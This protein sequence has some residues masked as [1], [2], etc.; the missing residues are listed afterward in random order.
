VDFKYAN[1]GC[2]ILAEYIDPEGTMTLRKTK[3]LSTSASVNRTKPRGGPDF[4]PP[5]KRSTD[6]DFSALIKE[7]YEDSDQF[8][9]IMFFVTHSV[10]VHAQVKEFKDSLRESNPTKTNSFICGVKT[11][12]QIE[13]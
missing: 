3:S 8:T 6:N 9:P 11:L 10:D 2:D 4:L 7:A 12:K 5:K 13:E 1:F